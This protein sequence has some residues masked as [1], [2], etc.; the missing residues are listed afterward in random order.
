MSQ[1]LLGMGLGLT[2][3]FGISRALASVSVY[4]DAGDLFVYGAVTITFLISGLLACAV[5]ARRAT[6]VNIVDSLRPD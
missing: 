5:P 6:L 2:L 3:G 4:V 1:L